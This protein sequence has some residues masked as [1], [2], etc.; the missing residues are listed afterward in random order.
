[1]KTRWFHF[2]TQAVSPLRPVMFRPR[3]PDPPA[4]GAWGDGQLAPQSY[5]RRCPCP[6]RNRN[7]K[8]IKNH[9][10]NKWHDEI[11]D[12]FESLLISFPNWFLFLFGHSCFVW[13]LR[14]MAPPSAPPPSSPSSP[15]L[16]AQPTPSWS[17]LTRGAPSNCGTKDVN[18]LIFSS[19]SPGRSYSQQKSM[20]ILV[21]GLWSFES[22][23]HVL[24]I[25]R[26]VHT[27]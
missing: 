19:F 6:D 18:V 3:A 1:M 21:L 15:H 14:P 9:H 11:F 10:M 23:W 26:R 5:G 7:P 24:N 13:N 2:A 4:P 16:G 8:S 20:S 27:V 12:L 17:G 22:I 25:R